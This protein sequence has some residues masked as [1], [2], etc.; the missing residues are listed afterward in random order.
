MLTKD[1]V[2]EAVERAI[3]SALNAGGFSNAGLAVVAT[4]KALSALDVA[5]W[6]CVP[7]EPTEAMHRAAAEGPRG[8]LYIYRGMLAA[9]PKLTEDKP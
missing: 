5:G 1:E 6:Q 3:C 4:R 9:A 7:K 2:I 8:S